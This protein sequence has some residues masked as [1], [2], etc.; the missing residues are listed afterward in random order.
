MSSLC[1]YIPNIGLGVVNACMSPSFGELR[2]NKKF[3]YLLHD[4]C[5]EG[6][7]FPLPFSVVLAGLIHKADSED[8]SNQI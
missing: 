4:D 2:V 8:K 3:Y 1:S 5:G 7:N 6:R